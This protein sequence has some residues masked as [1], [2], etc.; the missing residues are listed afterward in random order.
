MTIIA[1]TTGLG[2]AFLGTGEDDGLQAA[3]IV[4][5]SA[6]SAR[7]Q[8]RLAKE[9]VT[10]V[11]A[12][13]NVTLLPPGG[14]RE[15]HKRLPSGVAL[16]SVETARETRDAGELVFHPRGITSAAVVS[17]SH[18]DSVYSVYI[19][20]IGSGRVFAEQRTLDQILKEQ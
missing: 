20:S 17:L 9:P 4:L 13:N 5:A 19:P 8:A 7:S 1:L 6:G 2:I 18:K 12:E 3:N 10:L 11:L 15:M 14:G 16:V